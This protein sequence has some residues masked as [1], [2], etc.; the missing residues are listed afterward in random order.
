MKISILQKGIAGFFII[1]LMLGACKKE[2][3]TPAEPIIDDV[4]IV[5][6]GSIRIG[7]SLPNGELKTSSPNI[8]LFIDSNFT[9]YAD[10]AAY[11]DVNADGKIDFEVSLTCLIS[12][13]PRGVGASSQ[14]VIKPLNDYSF[15]LTD[16]VFFVDIWE[17]DTLI[18]HN[19]QPRLF[20]K[21]FSKG[22]TIH[23]ADRWRN[24]LI[25][26]DYQYLLLSTDIVRGDPMHFKG[27]AGAWRDVKDKYIGIKYNKSL[28]WIKISIPSPSHVIISEIALNY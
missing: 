15:I 27:F 20:P 9:S 14:I 2:E 6:Q 28:G 19:P 7:D 1:V 25:G 4:T 22:E 13:H 12:Y 18:A 10:K 23:A 16:S 11:L 24:Y 8:D 26:G 21:P 3:P 17:N 5:P